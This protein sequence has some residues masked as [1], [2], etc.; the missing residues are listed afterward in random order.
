LKRHKNYSLSPLSERDERKTRERETRE[1]DETERDETERE[2]ERE[3]RER[4]REQFKEFNDFSHLP[5]N[6]FI[7][8]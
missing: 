6:H 1:R 2:R 3:R 4:E 8:Y 7:N 5:C